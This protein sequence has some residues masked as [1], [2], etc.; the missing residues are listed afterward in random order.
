V[1]EDLLDHR[2]LQDGRDDFQ[3]PAAAVRAALYVDRE[4]ALEHPGA[5]DVAWPDLDVL[6]LALGGCCDFGRMS[7]FLLALAAP[8]APAGAY[9]CQS[10]IWR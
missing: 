9:G 1:R 2:P 6:G 8:T 10:A 3:F 7:R 4:H 5:V